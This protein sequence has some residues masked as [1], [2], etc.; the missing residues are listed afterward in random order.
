MLL[1]IGFPFCMIMVAIAIAWIGS[2]LCCLLLV[3]VYKS[4]VGS[5]ARGKANGHGLM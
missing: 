1:A 3:V 5:Y 2:D 4:Y